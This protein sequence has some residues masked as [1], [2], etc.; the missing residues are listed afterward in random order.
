MGTTVATNALL[1]RQGN[2][3]ALLIT[4]GFSDLLKIGNQARPA[5]FDLRIHRPDPLFTCVEEI[6]E[7]V[8]VDSCPDSHLRGRAFGYPE[9]GEVV[10]TVSGERVRIL[11]KIGTSYSLAGSTVWARD[12]L[13]RLTTRHHSSQAYP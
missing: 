8:L 6:A 3:T 1:Q 9:T 12:V 5:M 2:E 4:K 10:T 13:I 7:R 11:E